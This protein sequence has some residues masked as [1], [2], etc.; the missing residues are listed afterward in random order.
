MLVRLIAFVLIAE[1][2]L[3]AVRVAQLVSQIGVYDGIAVTL[4]VLRGL[5]AAVQFMGGWLIAQR[6]PQGPATP[7]SS[8]ASDR[9]WPRN[10]RGRSLRVPR[11]RGSRR[12]RR[13]DPPQHTN[14]PRGRY[15]PEE[16]TLTRLRARTCNS[17]S[18]IVIPCSFSRA[19]A[20]DSPCRRSPSNKCSV[21][22]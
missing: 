20:L 19:L 6:R 14:A 9:S 17:T 5:L 22:T 3:T 21:P 15:S 16:R 7:P 10:A 4:I 1:S 18:S 12:A 2:M 13:R 11:L 8:S